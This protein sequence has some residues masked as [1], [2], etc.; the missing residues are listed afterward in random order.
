MWLNMKRQELI[1]KYLDSVLANEIKSFE[2]D[3]KIFLQN[4]LSSLKFKYNTLNLIECIYTE[5]PFVLSARFHVDDLVVVVKKRMFSDNNMLWNIVIQHNGQEFEINYDE[6]INIMNR[7]LNFK[8][9]E[10]SKEQEKYSNLIKSIY[11]V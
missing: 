6:Y 10:V 9:L 7:I 5:N 8:L 11:G 3:S 1:N 2:K 4:Q